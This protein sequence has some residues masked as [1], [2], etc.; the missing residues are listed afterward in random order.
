M[1]PK[2]DPH[3]EAL[4]VTNLPLHLKYRTLACYHNTNSLLGLAFP[5]R[6]HRCTSQAVLLVLLVVQ[7]KEVVQMGMEVELMMLEVDLMR[8][9]VGQMP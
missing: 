1:V 2:L 7:G 9:V 6:T 8:V 3:I 5:H 4:Y